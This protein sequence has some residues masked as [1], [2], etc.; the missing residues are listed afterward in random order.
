MFFLRWFK[1]VGDKQADIQY[2]CGQKPRKMPE[3][4]SCFIN[5]ACCRPG[6]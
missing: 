5:V 2:T 1:I 4:K 3:G 6:T